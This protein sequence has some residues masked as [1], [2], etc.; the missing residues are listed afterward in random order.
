M[1]EKLYLKKDGYEI[2]YGVYAPES[3]EGLPLIVY[4]HGAGERG[5]NY[6]HLTRHAIPM[7]IAEGRE[8]PAV[9][10]CPQCPAEFVWDNI[11]TTVK[12]IIDKVAEE[13]SVDKSRIC[14]T[15]SS[16]G[17]FGTWSM[18]L[19]YPNFFSAIAP[20]AGGGMAWRADNLRTTPVYA[21]HGALDT[22]VLPE[23]SKMM[24]EKVNQTGGRAELEILENYGHNDGINEVYRRGEVI[25]K[26]LGERRT[27]KEII[28]E[29]LSHMF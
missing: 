12:S 18:G 3:Y 14:I 17:G 24:V 26:L 29:H 10:L 22:A 4:L 6:S 15:G 25:D 23:L 16:M 11:V 13:Y 28:K 8:Y 1:K 9:V 7:L 19:T 20:I 5:E 2:N 21:Y 27:T